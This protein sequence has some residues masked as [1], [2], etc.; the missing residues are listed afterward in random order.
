MVEK[1]NNSFNWVGQNTDFVQDV[2]FKN[3]FKD[4]HLVALFDRLNQKISECR[5]EINELR[6]LIVKNSNPQT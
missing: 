4:V 1:N 3:Q 5:N 2:I 6:Q